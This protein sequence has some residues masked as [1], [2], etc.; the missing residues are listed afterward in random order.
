M[1]GHATPTLGRGFV[2]ALAA[3]DRDRLIAVLHPH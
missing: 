3:R 2:E 1:K